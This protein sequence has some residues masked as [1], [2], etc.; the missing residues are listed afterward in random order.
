VG[1]WPHETR[2]TAGKLIAQ[3]TI[4]ETIAQ[5]YGPRVHLPAPIPP[6]PIRVQAGDDPA[7]LMAMWEARRA[8]LPSSTA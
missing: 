5:H 1:G 6:V 8:A 4:A 7:A 2:F 3:V